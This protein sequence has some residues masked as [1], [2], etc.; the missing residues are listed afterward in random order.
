V[1]LVYGSQH[2]AFFATEDQARGYAERLSENE[3]G[4]S[5]LQIHTKSRTIYIN[6]EKK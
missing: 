4:N 3:Y 2:K 5:G 6:D 1:P